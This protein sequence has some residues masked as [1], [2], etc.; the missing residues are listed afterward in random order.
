MQ[1]LMIGRQLNVPAKD[2]ARAAWLVR[3]VVVTI[4]GAMA[5]LYLWAGIPGKF[6]PI[7]AGA[8]LMLVP[9]ATLYMAYVYLAA[10][11][12]AFTEPIRAT[13]GSPFSWAAL[14][15]LSGPSRERY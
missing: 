6:P 11:T 8:I 4:M 3:I 13:L 2:R 15:L 10:R 14:F 5:A 1:F 12:L 9:V 7:L